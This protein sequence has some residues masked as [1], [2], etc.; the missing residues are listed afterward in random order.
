LLTSCH[1][2]ATFNAT[3]GAMK[4]FYNGQ[5]VATKLHSSASTAP[6]TFALDESDMYI[7]Q[8]PSIGV[9]SQ[10]FGEIHE[11]AVL[12][13]FKT[14]YDTIFTLAPKFDRTLL[15]YRFEEVDL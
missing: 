5:E 15:Y 2:A 14:Q 8:D 3:S 9:T 7:G 10:F 13:G 12:S 1:I 11:F 6:Y 4:V